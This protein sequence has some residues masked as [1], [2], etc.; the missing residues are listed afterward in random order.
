MYWKITVASDETA[1]SNEEHA[2]AGRFV[3]QRHHDGAGP[4]WDLRL[5]QAGH[6]VGWRFERPLSG[7]GCWASEKGPHPMRWLEHDGDT[8]REDGGLYTVLEWSKNTRALL[9]EGRNGTRTLRATRMPFVPPET[10]RAIQ[11]TMDAFSVHPG[12][13]AAVLRDGITA[14]RRAIERFCGLGRELDGNAFDENV[15]RR[16][17]DSLTL[18]ELTAHLRTYEV[19]FDHKFPPSPASCPEALPESGDGSRTNRAMGIV[20]GG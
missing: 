9:L 10:A 12:A 14:R 6:L 4:H 16:T 20:R 7:D 19:R 8:V 1:P 15:W 18:D 5:E 13:L 2:P 11:E 17:L 3:L